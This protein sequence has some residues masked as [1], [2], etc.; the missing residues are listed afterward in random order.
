MPQDAPRHTSYSWRGWGGAPGAPTGGSLE[1]GR[2]DGDDDGAGG[3]KGHPAASWP[4][5]KRTKDAESRALTDGGDHRDG[6]VKGAGESPLAAGSVRLGPQ[7]QPLKLPVVFRR[8]AV[9]LSEVA[10]LLLQEALVA[11]LGLGLERIEDGGAHQQIGENA[12]DEGD[13]AEV[14][15]LHGEQAAAPRRQHQPGRRMVPAQPIRPP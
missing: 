4:K 5:G 12:D 7:D 13:R 8:E 2:G 10:A 9:L 15:P 1:G 3:G 6:K 14:L 11:D